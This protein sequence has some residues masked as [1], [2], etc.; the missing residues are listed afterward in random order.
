MKRIL[1]VLIILLLLASTVLCVHAAGSASVSGP[2]TVRAGDTF[3]VYFTAGGGILGGS[4]SVSYDPAVLT[5][6]G[7]SQ[8]IGGNW[9]VEFVGNNFVFYDNNMNSPISGSATIFT[10]TFTANQDLAPGT[11]IAVSFNG[12]TLS[13]GDSDTV[14]GTRTYSTQIAPPLSSD[15]SLKSLIITNASLSPAFSADNTTYQVSVP[16]TVSQLELSAQA[17]DEKAQVAISNPSLIAGGTTAVEV[18]VT[19]ENGATRVYTIYVSREQDPNYVKSNDAT[20]KNLSV[21]GFLLS[22]VFSLDVKQYYVWLPYEQTS[23]KI[24]AEAAHGLASVNVGVV[25]ELIPGHGND[26]AVT[27]TAEDGTQQIYTVTAVRAPAL[28]DTEDYLGGAREPAPEPETEPPTE[29]ATEP[30]TEPT[31]SP[32]APPTEPDTQPTEPAEKNDPITMIVVGCIG[33]LLG[34][35]ISLPFVLLT[36]RK[37]RYRRR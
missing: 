15:C 20:L 3:T 17:A 1:T 18:T 7:Y 10:A 25:P 16:F 33:L 6:Q 29:P 27:V 5:L 13:D 26:I 9:E 4:G 12:I 11:E 28:A 22:P 36:G 34:I 31:Q 14:V 35:V 8:H 19:A 37:R 32:T 23:V 2:D 30:A 21:E 24:L